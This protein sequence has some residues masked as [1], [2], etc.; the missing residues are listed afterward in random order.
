VG[1]QETGTTKDKASVQIEQWVLSS[2]N[3]NQCTPLFRTDT[4]HLSTDRF[5]RPTARWRCFHAQQAEESDIQVLAQWSDDVTYP[6]RTADY[7]PVNCVQT[8]MDVCDPSSGGSKS[9][10][11]DNDG[12]DS[13]SLALSLCVCVVVLFF[14]SL[15]SLCYPSIKKNRGCKLPLQIGGSY[16]IMFSI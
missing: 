11:F 8:K 16:K 9:V 14:C 13:V 1:L 4:R 12:S 3:G 7:A 10:H 5:P 15:F 6:R 2:I